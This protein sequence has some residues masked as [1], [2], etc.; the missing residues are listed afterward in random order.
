M[1]SIPTRSS[2]DHDATPEERALKL[3]SFHNPTRQRGDTAI[4]IDSLTRRVMKILLWQ[5]KAQPQN[6][7]AG[8]IVPLD[9]HQRSTVSYRNARTP[10][11]VDA[12]LVFTLPVVDPAIQ[13]NV[14]RVQSLCLLE[15]EAECWTRWIDPAIT[16]T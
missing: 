2:I 14:E 4:D 11:A 5:P 7:H 13:S 6:E 3:R 1:P 9:V 16:Q 15:T 8:S 10:I 12:R